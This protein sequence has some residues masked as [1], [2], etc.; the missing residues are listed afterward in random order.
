MKD[1][2][3]LPILAEA[4]TALHRHC[5]QA[6][7]SMIGD[8]PARAA[9]QET[10]EAHGLGAA[11]TWHGRVAPDQ[12]PALLAELDVAVAPYP[13]L[14]T[15]YFS[16]LKVYEYMAAGLPVVASDLGQLRQLIRPGVNGLLC[17]PGDAAAL[18]DQLSVLAGQPQL[19]QRLGLAARQTVVE[20]HSWDR[21]VKDIL[22][23]AQ[24][25]AVLEKVG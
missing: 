19:R 20:H 10:L 11:V 14:D 22:A 17:P 13:R 21:R 8:G 16:P 23:L 9:M 5:P 4:F 18:A 3:G 2:H 12:I 15:F 6:R 1:W 7:L 25:D 24:R